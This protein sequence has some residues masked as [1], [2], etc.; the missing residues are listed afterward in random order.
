MTFCVCCIDFLFLPQHMLMSGE[1]TYGLYTIKWLAT[2]LRTPVHQ[3]FMQ[4]SN[5]TI[6]WEQH[7]A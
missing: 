5:Q 6:M 3:P 2:L 1:N 4:L 7:S